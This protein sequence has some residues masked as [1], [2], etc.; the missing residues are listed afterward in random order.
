MSR[1]LSLAT[2]PLAATQVVAQTYTSCN[3]LNSTCPSDV[4]LGTSHTFNWT[5][6]TAAPTSIWNTTAGTVNFETTGAEFT[7]SN[8]EPLY[9]ANSRADQH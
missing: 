9:A 6:G 3:P 2:L 5:T 7:V 1:F 8:S 4:A